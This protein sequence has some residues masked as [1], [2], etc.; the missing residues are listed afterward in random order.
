MKRYMLFGFDGYYP[1][2]G[3]NDLLGIFDSTEEMDKHFIAEYIKEGYVRRYDN[4]QVFDTEK[5][6]ELGYSYSLPDFES[7]E[8]D[9]NNNSE[10]EENEEYISKSN[11][12]IDAYLSGTIDKA[13]LDRKMKELK[14]QNSN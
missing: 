9:N 1:R 7:I 11:L 10:V 6:K 5:E 13:V 8:L 14:L 12:L 3:V 4:F 2:G